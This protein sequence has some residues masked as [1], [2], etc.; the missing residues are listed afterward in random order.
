[1]WRTDS[2]E[3]TLTLGK[4][5]GRRRRGLQRMRWLDGITTSMDMSLSKLGEMVKDREACLG[6]V[7]GVTE[8]DMTEWTTTHI[9]ICF[10]SPLAP[11]VLSK[12]GRNLTL[13]L[14]TA[15]S[16]SLSVGFCIQG[17]MPFGSLFT[18][19]HAW[20]C[21]RHPV[22]ACLAPSLCLCLPLAT[23]FLSNFVYISNSGG[24]A[25]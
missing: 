3:K 14:W 25:L 15:P 23:L 10:P 4:I 12:H 19:S 2:L 17:R 20:D 21:Q 8:S 24:L 1:M 22:L 9:S 7:H 5:E 18:E 13:A 16:A 6:V 11:S